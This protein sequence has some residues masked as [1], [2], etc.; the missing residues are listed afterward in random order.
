MKVHLLASEPEEGQVGFGTREGALRLNISH[1][2]VGSCPAGPRT[3][4]SNQPGDRLLVFGQQSQRLAPLWPS[5]CLSSC[6]R[7]QEESWALRSRPG[8]SRQERGRWCLLGASRTFRSGSLAYIQFF[9]S[10]LVTGGFV[11]S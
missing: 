5:S 1:H 6:L 8:D 10:E 2:P 7:K 11:E 9:A 3:S 4:I